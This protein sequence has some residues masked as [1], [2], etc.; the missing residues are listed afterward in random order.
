MSTAGFE[1][2]IPESERPQAHALVRAATAIGS[3]WYSIQVLPLRLIASV[4]NALFQRML[5]P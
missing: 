1:P 2:A 4:S 5:L 3:E